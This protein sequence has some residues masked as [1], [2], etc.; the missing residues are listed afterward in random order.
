MVVG[1][2]CLTGHGDDNG[3]SR[4]VVAAAAAAAAVRASQVLRCQ[5]ALLGEKR[6]RACETQCVQR[7]FHYLP[8]QDERMKRPK[9]K[10]GWSVYG[11]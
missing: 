7:E 2:P 6:M 1:K 11:Q 8:S 9:G 10:I 4:T 3:L 5:W